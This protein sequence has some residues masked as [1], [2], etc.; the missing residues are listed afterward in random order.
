MF[1]SNVCNGCHYILMMSMK[2]NDVVI[3]N[4]GGVDNRCIIIGISKSEVINLFKKMLIEAKK[5]GT[6]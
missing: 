3:L 4:I 2:L 5:R 1:Q 6:L